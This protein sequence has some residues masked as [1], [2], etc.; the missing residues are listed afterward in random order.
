[1]N[2]FSIK[3]WGKNDVEA[4]KHNGKKWRNEKDLEKALRYKNLAS[5][6]TQYYSDKFKKRRCEMQDCEDFLPCRKII[7]E[8]LAV[9]LITDIK[10][11]KAGEL[12]INLGFNQIDPVMTKQRVISLRL[13]ML[14]SNEEIIEY[15]SALNYLID[16]YFPKYKLAIEVDELGHKDKDQ[17]KEKKRRKDLKEYLD[18]TFIRINPDQ[19]IF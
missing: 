15:F 14:F 18:C 17:T 10:T 12:K 5:N 7:A 8:E 3:P 11:I 2:T 16:F 13:K 6:K 19:K 4:I 1:M 9:H